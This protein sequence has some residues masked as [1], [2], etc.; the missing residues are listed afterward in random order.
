MLKPRIKL[1]HS[2]LRSHAGHLCFGEAGPNIHVLKKPDDFVYE[3]IKQL[4]GQNTIPKI[5]RN[6][7][8]KFPETNEEQIHLFIQKISE[9]HLVDDA[10]LE[11]SLLS[12]R[13]QE[14]YNR[15][16]LLFSLLEHQNRPGHFYQE[17]IKNKHVVILGLG[18][19]GTWLALN[20]SLLGVGELTLVDGDTVELSNLNRQV[21]YRHENIGQQKA[22]AA[23]KC[24]EH[25]NPYIKINA[26]SEFINR[27]EK[28]IDPFIREKDL[29]FIA[30]ANLS[31][32]RKNCVD[33]II[34]QIAIQ[35]KVPIFEVNADPID[36]SVG[37]LY[38]NDGHSLTF[39]DIRD[40]VRKKWLNHSQVNV[41]EFRK[42][43]MTDN[44]YNGN[45]ICNAWQQASSLSA[46]AG[47]ATSEAMK[48]LGQYCPPA[49]IG[50]EF[51]LNLMT[52]QSHLIDF[53]EKLKDNISPPVI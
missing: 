40:I 8:N 51:A 38:L 13:E 48:L 52:F 53:N 29:V 12:A 6:V 34:H 45:R 10:A 11:P 49:L 24:L 43:R 22:L 27:D 23:K 26:Y 20:L 16:M 7:L 28:Q 31:Y 1:S 35:H 5:V 9:L 3:I 15:Q 25:I 47:L 36:I 46:M 39:F 50:K 19:W 18:G 14:L 30:W 4:D 33:E 21:L 37:P 17:N 32:Y 2:V 42:S 44:F 41:S